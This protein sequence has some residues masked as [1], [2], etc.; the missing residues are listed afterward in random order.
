MFAI[1]KTNYRRHSVGLW[2]TGTISHDLAH[3]QLGRLTTKLKRSLSGGSFADVFLAAVFQVQ[4][5]NALRTASY[6]QDNLRREVR[7]QTSVRVLPRILT[8]DANGWGIGRK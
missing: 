3:I 6:L 2:L 4:F 5:L 8:R 7:M 1:A